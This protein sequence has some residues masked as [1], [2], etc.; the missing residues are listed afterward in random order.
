MAGSIPCTKTEDW[1]VFSF[2]IKN[3][4]GIY[5]HSPGQVINTIQHLYHAISLLKIINWF[6]L[7]KWKMRW[8][9]SGYPTVENIH[10]SSWGWGEMLRGSLSWPAHKISYRSHVGEKLKCNI[11]NSPFIFYPRLPFCTQGIWAW[12]WCFLSPPLCSQPLWGIFPCGL[13]SFSKSHVSSHVSPLDTGPNNTVPD[14]QALGKHLNEFWN[15][16]KNT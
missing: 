7:I 12:F 6:H 16:N 13:S 4:S 10:F 15:L 9:Q 5:L 1:S 2:G 8:S 3:L 14:T 11:N